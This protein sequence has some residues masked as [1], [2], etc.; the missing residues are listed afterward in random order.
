MP[1]NPWLRPIATLLISR[2]LV[3]TPYTNSL[4]GAAATLTS[5][6]PQSPSENAVFLPLVQ[7]DPAIP[8]KA[9]ADSVFGEAA[10]VEQVALVKLDVAPF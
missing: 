10:L 1:Y 5:G 8:L 6:Q 9:E 4:A 2:I 7:N 3:C